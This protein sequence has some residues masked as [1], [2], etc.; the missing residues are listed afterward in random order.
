MVSL[1]M[2]YAMR[3]SRSRIKMNRMV[4]ICCVD[5]EMVEAVGSALEG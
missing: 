2:M 3:M 5:G 4:C 1:H